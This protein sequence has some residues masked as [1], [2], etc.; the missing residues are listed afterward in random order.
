MTVASEVRITES[1]RQAA[2]ETAARIGNKMARLR[3]VVPSMLDL[4]SEKQEAYLLRRDIG[5]H[6]FCRTS[7]SGVAG[8]RAVA[9]QR[10]CMLLQA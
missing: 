3:D 8:V 6:S 2:A 5:C 9:P 4:G 1:D 7:P 10:A